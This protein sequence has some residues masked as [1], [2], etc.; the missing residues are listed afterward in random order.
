MA[1][2]QAT[3]LAKA[4]QT[5]YDAARS[6]K[7][8]EGFH[9]KQARLLMRELDGIRRTCAELGITLTIKTEAKETVHGRRQEQQPRS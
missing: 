9:R 2:E 1:T 5:L 4:A 6:H 8:S 3:A 7:R